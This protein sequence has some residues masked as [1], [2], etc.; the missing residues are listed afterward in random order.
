MELLIG[1]EDPNFVKIKDFYE[2]RMRYNYLSV[3]IKDKNYA[4]RETFY[5][6]LEDWILNLEDR[7]DHYPKLFP[8]LLSGLFDSSESIQSLTI[9]I[10]D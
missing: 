10:L 4:S 6:V 5:Y 7:E 2:N 8:Y 3:F 1:F 9:E